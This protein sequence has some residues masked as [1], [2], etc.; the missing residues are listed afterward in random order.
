MSGGRH[1]GQ[2]SARVFKRLILQKEIQFPV[3]PIT[4]CTTLDTPVKLS[5]LQFSR[6]LGRLSQFLP[7]QL[8]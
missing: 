3:L 6:L 1:I 7:L 2:C 8:S 4:A 5:K